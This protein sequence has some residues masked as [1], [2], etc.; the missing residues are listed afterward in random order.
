MINID[1]NVQNRYLT[2]NKSHCWQYDI[3]LSNIEKDLKYND[4]TLE[5]TITDFLIDI[6][7]NNVI[8]KLYDNDPKKYIRKIKL[9]KING[10]R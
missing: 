10:K 3:R 9:N 1:N 7:F 4:L 8:D 6:D 2:Y 5:E